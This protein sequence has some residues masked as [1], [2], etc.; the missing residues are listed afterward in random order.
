[1]ATSSVRALLVVALSL[2]AAACRRPAGSADAGAPLEAEV[3]VRERTIRA[4]VV[5]TVAAKASPGLEA[6][7]EE[8]FGE[9][10]KVDDV[11]SDW[12]DGS[13]LAALNRAAGQGPR[14]VS[15]PLFELLRT[16]RGLSEASDGA[17]DVTFASLHGLW[18]FDQEAPRIPTDAELKE[19]LPLLGYRHLVLDEAAQTAALDAP[20]VRVGL[21][22][23]GDGYASHLASAA[24]TRRGFP[25]HLVL[26]GGDGVGRGRR[27]DRAWRVAIRHPESGGF[28]GAVELHDEGVAT[29]GNY[30][31]YFVQDGVRYH[32]LLDPKTGRPSRGASSVTVLAKDGLLADGWATALFVLGPQRGLE[33]ARREGLEALWFDEEFR[34]TGTPGMLARVQ[35]LP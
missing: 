13:E 5:I 18:R 15:A 31:R 7:I 26:I 25:D 29:S 12:R 19:R 27:K 6:A 16:A 2:C 23:L 34:L 14:K 11:L 24:L 35:P 22:A 8:A 4:Q 17:F 10:Q 32:H 30:E 33:V 1:M 9:V 3:T 28:H 20:G 21:G